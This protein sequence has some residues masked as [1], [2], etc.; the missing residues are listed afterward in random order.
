MGASHLFRRLLFGLA[1]TCVGPRS[2]SAIEVPP[3]GP[4]GTPDAEGARA[5]FE[6]AVA[7]LGRK[8][9]DEVDREA[10][11]A[12]QLGFG[13]DA[14]ELVAVAALQ[15]TRVSLAHA[16]YVALKG[17]PT[18]PNGPRGRAERQT[19]A[20]AGQGGQ[21][22]LQGVP[23]G[24]RVLVDG[25]YLGPTPLPAPVLAMAGAHRLSIEAAG[26]RPWERS[27]RFAKGKTVNVEVSLEPLASP[28]APAPSSAAEPA[29][30]SGVSHEARFG[31]SP[32][33]SAPDLEPGLEQG[34]VVPLVGRRVDVETRF[35][36]I[37]GVRLL[38]IEAGI[39][40]LGEPEAPQRLPLSV[41]RRITPLPE[42][43]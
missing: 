20:L 18:V 1:V 5:A 17:D 8:K 3:L 39:V 33:Q 7:A 2:A 26:F 41:L 6:R 32:R 40:A 13:A 34:A 30:A 42:A 25:E 10:R 9:F 28:V 35:G 16:V 15:R 23:A 24:A 43:R 37:A 11:A 12:W 31:P 19:T 4:V 38:G 21:V 14:A 36:R 29:R 27:L 22:V